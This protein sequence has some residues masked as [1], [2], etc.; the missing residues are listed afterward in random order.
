MDQLSAK[1]YILPSPCCS[2]PG[3]PTS[4]SAPPP[5]DANST[6]WTLPAVELRGNARPVHTKEEGCPLGGGVINPRPLPRSA[7]R[8]KFEE[9]NDSTPEGLTH[10]VWRMA[11]EQDTTVIVINSGNHERIGIRHR[12]SQTLYLSD[13]IDLTKPGYGKLHVG[14][15]I[16]AVDDA[17]DRYRALHEKNPATRSGKRPRPTASPEKV[18]LRRSKRQ[19]MN[20]LLEQ[21]RNISTLSQQDHKVL[22]REVAQRSLL[23]LRFGGLCSSVPTCCLRRGKPLSLLVQDPIDEVSN[24]LDEAY[25]AS[26]YVLLTLDWE[27]SSGKTGQVYTGHL[28]LMLPSGRKLLRNVVAKIAHYKAAQERVRHEY[29]VYQ[30]L[31]SHKVKRIP[32]IYG[33]FEDVDNLATVLVMERAAFTFRQRDPITE[34]N[35]GLLQEIQP[36][37]RLACMAIVKEI[38]E[39]GVVHRDLRAENL[40]VAQDGK[41]MFID[42]DRAI[43]DPREETKSL[44]IRSLSDLL[45]GKK[46]RR[47]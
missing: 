19:K 23:L 45:V 42:F 22:W 21:S 28:Q 14:I 26:E 11:V 15:L 46:F 17:L 39:A 30:R 5:C 3:F 43:L 32:E 29:Q 41:P 13:M 16:S 37:E 25:Q 18:E 12:G 34:E 40:V 7:P 44:E 10:H 1:G 9:M 24:I 35:N 2:T 6:Q 38:H 36:S 20:L 4:Q 8:S 33:L 31:W 27:N 47:L